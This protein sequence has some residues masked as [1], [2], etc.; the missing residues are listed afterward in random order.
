MR[1]SR[2]F[3]GGRQHRCLS[4]RRRDAGQ[5]LPNH[6]DS[7]ISISPSTTSDN[8]RLDRILNPRVLHSPSVW[9]RF[10]SNAPLMVWVELTG[11]PTAARAATMPPAANCSAIAATGRTR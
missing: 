11:A 9:G 5:A 6:S 8:H 1:H 3:N 7:C 4:D 2:D 10:F